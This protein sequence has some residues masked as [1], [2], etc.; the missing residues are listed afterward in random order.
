MTL[1]PT[2]L[3]MKPSMA[4]TTR[5]SMSVKPRGVVVIRDIRLAEP[6]D[7]ASTSS[8]GEQSAF[9]VFFSAFFVTTFSELVFCGSKEC[10]F[11]EARGAQRERRYACGQTPLHFLK[12]RANVV[13][14]R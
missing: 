8:P 1:G 4:M 12:A 6:I 7:V 14:S 10:P 13:K 3:A 9:F 11:E 2:R 5:S